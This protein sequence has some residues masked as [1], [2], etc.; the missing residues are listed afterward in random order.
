MNRRRYLALCGISITGMSGCVAENNQQQS[1][2]IPT[3]TPPTYNLDIGFSGLQSGVVELFEDAY[4]LTSTP[5]SQYL[6][7]DVTVP[8]GPRPEEGDFAFRFDGEEYVPKTD[9]DYPPLHR[10]ENSSGEYPDL[11]GDERYRSDVDRDGWIV[12]ELPE[13]GDA[14]EAVLSW[15][16]G[17]WTPDESVRTR[18]ANQLPAFSLDA[19]N[20]PETVSSTANPEFELS[21]RNVGTQP[22]QFWGAVDGDGELTTTDRMVTLVTKRISPGE[23]ESW[24]VTGTNSTLPYV[25]MVDDNEEVTHRYTLLWEG[26]AR[27]QSARVSYE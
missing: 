14:S 4:E 25:D 18:L 3:T 6:F 9:W 22:G 2:D 24:R 13:Q 27:S 19:W 11:T 16:G 12:F 20:V 8:S 15:S 5:D 21:V 23:T 1:T 17:E 10:A 26:E 7:L